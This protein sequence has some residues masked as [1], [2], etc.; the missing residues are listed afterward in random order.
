MLPWPTTSS[1]ELTPP[2]RLFPKP[3]S[4]RAPLRLCSDPAPTRALRKASVAATA[5]SNTTRPSK[6]QH[7]LSLLSQVLYAPQATIPKQRRRL[8]SGNHLLRPP[9][10][11]HRSVN[12]RAGTT[13]RRNELASTL[14]VP[15]VP[16]LP[17]RNFLLP[18]HANPSPDPP[19]VPHSP[20]TLLAPNPDSRVAPSP[21][22]PLKLVAD[23]NLD[24]PLQHFSPS[25]TLVLRNNGS[26]RAST[27][28]DRL[29]GTLSF[30]DLP[31][32]HLLL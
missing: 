21:L 31:F 22:L 16:Q 11:L 4:R 9:V 2:L 23:P 24:H 8:T 28:L 14:E 15:R 20:P 13:R 1:H 30:D 27:S 12:R 10:W 3:R 29:A 32:R 26:S 18:P 17:P 7:Q 6:H 25:K 19:R 5:R